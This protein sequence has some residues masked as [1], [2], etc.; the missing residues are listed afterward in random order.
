MSTKIL[1][2]DEVTPL[3]WHVTTPQDRTSGHGKQMFINQSK[4]IKERIVFQLPPTKAPF[5]VQQ[6]DQEGGG[7][8]SAW[9]SSLSVDSSQEMT[10]VFEQI[11]QLLLKHAIAEKK[12]WFSKPIDD[13]KIALK[14]FTCVKPSTSPDWPDKIKLKIIKAGN[15]NES[16][17][18]KATVNPD[19]GS[20]NGVSKFNLVRV[21]EDEI[22][23]GC[24]V[25]AIVEVGGAWVS[26]IGF[27]LEL[28]IQQMFFVHDDVGPNINQFQIEGGVSLQESK[29]ESDTGEKRMIDEMSS[30]AVGGDTT[31]TELPIPPKIA[32]L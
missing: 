12:M 21:A 23:K 29:I 19:Y 3:E 26:Q 27:G 9:K 13:E 7:A 20:V 32:K 30:E 6:P 11:D 2:F 5:G 31:T 14:Q 16:K 1:K 22:P 8:Y 25:T 15:Q 18:Y 28:R 24:E 17:I 10:K 4:D